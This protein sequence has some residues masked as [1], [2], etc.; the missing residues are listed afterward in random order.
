MALILAY[1]P[2]EC[3]HALG[4]IATESPRRS[5]ML[6]GLIALAIGGFGT[7]MTEFVI[8]G[9]LPSVASDL[10]VNEATAGWLI[11]GYALSVVVGALVA[12]SKQPVGMDPV[13]KGL[14]SDGYWLL[15]TGYPITLCPTYEGGQPSWVVTTKGR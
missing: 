2:K 8:M 10:H 7:G 6:L 9:L 4:S 3:Q 12:T 5:G 13:K 1:I 11:S 14:V 15:A